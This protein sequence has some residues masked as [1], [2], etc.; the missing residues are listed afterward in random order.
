[1]EWYLYLKLIHTSKEMKLRCMYDKI[2][3]LPMNKYAFG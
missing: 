1:M 2:D 3:R